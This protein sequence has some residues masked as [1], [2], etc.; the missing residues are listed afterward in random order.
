MDI[1]ADKGHILS[2]TIRK[3][4]GMFDGL[5]ACT[6]TSEDPR[7]FGICEKILKV[8]PLSQI[9]CISFKE[10]ENGIPKLLEINPRAMGSIN[11]STL[12]GNDA[13]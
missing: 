6:E 3:N 9:F 13:P 5:S 2:C 1:L 10:D 11:I 12:A 4:L 7:L 8:L